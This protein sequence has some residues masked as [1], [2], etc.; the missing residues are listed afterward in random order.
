MRNALYYEIID[1]SYIANEALISDNLKLQSRL[2]N[3]QK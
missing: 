2:E 3:S 1:L